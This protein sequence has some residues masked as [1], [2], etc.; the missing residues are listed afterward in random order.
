M[1][2]R[3]FTGIAIVLAVAATLPSWSIDMQGTDTNGDGVVD[4]KEATAAGTLENQFKEMDKDG[5]GKLSPDKISDVKSAPTS[6]NP[7]GEGNVAE[8]GIDGATDAPPH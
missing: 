3:L 5:D 2:T 8:P 1:K 4:P 6:P 7:S